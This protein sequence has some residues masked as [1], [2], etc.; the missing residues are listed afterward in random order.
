[1]ADK[2]K[3]ES[4]WYNGR[5]RCLI[6]EPQN[7]CPKGRLNVVELLRSYICFSMLGNDTYVYIIPENQ[8]ST[9]LSISVYLNVERIRVGRHITDNIGV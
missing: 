9:A 3:F 7:I 4:P 5:S 8:L 6:V 1:M 2:Q